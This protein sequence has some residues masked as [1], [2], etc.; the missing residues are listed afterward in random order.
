MAVLCCGDRGICLDSVAPSIVGQKSSRKHGHRSDISESTASDD[1]KLQAVPEDDKDSPDEEGGNH[2]E[3]GDHVH[4]EGSGLEDETIFQSLWHNFLGEANPQFKMAILGS[5]LLNPIILLIAGPT[6]ATWC[7]LLQFLFTLAMALEAYPLQAGGM[8]VIEANL[9]NLTNPHTLLHEVT[10][11]LNVIIMVI[12]MVASIHFLKNLLLWVFTKILLKVKD[13]TQLCVFF[14]LTATIMSAFLDA[15][16][17]SAVVVSVC[18]GFLA[19]YYYVV[20]ECS[21]PRLNQ[22]H[23]SRGRP[24]MDFQ[25]MPKPAEKKM[26]RQYTDDQVDYII[27]NR[28]TSKQSVHTAESSDFGN[29]LFD[30]GPQ[31]AAMK[32]ANSLVNADGTNFDMP[33][34]DMVL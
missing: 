19:V 26:S 29:L 30:S 23:N 27:A 16:T 20:K 25:L 4:K 32:Q 13:K 11:N 7:V 14:L 33:K 17:V 8:L 1:K 22:L 21:L 6:I 28:S 31:T 24:E 2:D 34:L 10:S 12:F 5:L 3:D 9:L 15:L 18:S